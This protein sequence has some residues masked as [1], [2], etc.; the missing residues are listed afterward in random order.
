L[1]FIERDVDTESEK[2][3]ETLGQGFASLW[4]KLVVFEV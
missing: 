3:L 4:A 1:A 2:H